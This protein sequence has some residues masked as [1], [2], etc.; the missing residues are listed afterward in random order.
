MTRLLIHPQDPCHLHAEV[1]PFVTVRRKGRP[2]L[3]Y[4]RAP[5]LYMKRTSLTYSSNARDRSS[6]VA[7]HV[8]SGQTLC[9][10]STII[11]SIVRGNSNRHV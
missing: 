1:T 11:R 5:V 6:G 2:T 9:E 10:V 3:E 7:P 8:E 4:L